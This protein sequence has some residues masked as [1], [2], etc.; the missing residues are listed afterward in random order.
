MEKF[1]T[2]FTDLHEDKR[3]KGS[4]DY[5]GDYLIDRIDPWLG[6]CNILEIKEDWQNNFFKVKN[7][8]SDGLSHPDLTPS[9]VIRS[10][11]G[12]IFVIDN[13]LVGV[14]LGWILDIY[15]SRLDIAET[16]K[17]TQFEIDFRD[18]SILL[19]EIGSAIDSGKFVVVERLANEYRQKFC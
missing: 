11:D 1:K 17:L 4:F 14:G 16:R 6:Y 2:D 18:R 15:N 8:L 3:F 9:N 10:K 7:Q 19:R 13:E 5:L 12:K